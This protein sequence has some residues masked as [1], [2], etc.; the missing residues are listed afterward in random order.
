MM[1]KEQDIRKTKREQKFK[2]AVRRNGINNV[3]AL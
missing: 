3:E 2:Q 1:Q